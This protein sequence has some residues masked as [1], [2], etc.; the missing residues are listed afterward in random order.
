MSNPG[1]RATAHAP[2]THDELRVAVAEL[3]SRG[4]SVSTIARC[5]GIAVEAVRVLLGEK[6][7][8]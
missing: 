4:Y 1:D 2:R 3:A 7:T 5:V 8:T 6:V